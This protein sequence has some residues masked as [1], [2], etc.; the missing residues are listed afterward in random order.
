MYPDGSYFGVNSP[1]LSPSP[2]IAWS[3]V[4]RGPTGHLNHWAEFESEDCPSTAPGVIYT[5]T[6]AY[7][8]TVGINAALGGSSSPTVSCNVVQTHA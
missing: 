3:N 7:T 6:N 4:L 8:E 1:L 2:T 5:V